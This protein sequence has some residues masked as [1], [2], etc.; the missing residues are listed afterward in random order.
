MNTPLSRSRKG[1]RRTKHL[2]WCIPVLLSG[3][4]VWFANHPP[5]TPNT[6]PSAAAVVEVPR[7]QLELRSNRLHQIGASNAFNGWMVEYYPD[8]ALRSRSAVTNGLLHGLSQ[9]WHTNGQLQVS[10]Y[11]VAGIS[12]GPRSKWYPSG[13]KQ[14]EAHIADGRLNGPFRRWHENG[15]L[16]EKV[17]FV[18]DQPEGLSLAYFPSGF[19]KARATMQHGQ[20]LSREFWQDGEKQE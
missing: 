12:H 20:P 7:T 3:P 9:G 17:E 18:A 2:L 8:G 15:T 11:F 1:F 4:L 13:S 5:L 16:S 10:E 19:L 6:P 14:S